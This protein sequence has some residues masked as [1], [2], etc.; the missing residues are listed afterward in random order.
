MT[1]A[2]E[3]RPLRKTNRDR[4]RRVGRSLIKV[5]AFTYGDAGLTIHQWR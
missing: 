1:D 5:G 4:S 2:T 3:P